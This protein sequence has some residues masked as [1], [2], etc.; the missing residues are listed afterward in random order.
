[1]PTVHP[2][3]S[4]CDA[5]QYR[6][7]SQPTAQPNRAINRKTATQPPQFTVS[8]RVHRPDQRKAAL[9]RIL[10]SLDTFGSFRCVFSLLILPLSYTQIFPRI[11][12]L[13]NFFYTHNQSA[14]PQ[15]SSAASQAISSRR[16]S[17]VRRRSALIRRRSSVH[18]P[19]AISD[20]SVQQP[21]SSSEP[22]RGDCSAIAA[23]SI[24]S[25]YYRS[26]PVYHLNSISLFFF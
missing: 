6:D 1:M 18:S 19:P 12:F 22:L 13:P 7:T 17:H 11:F 10:L 4:A 15:Q 20:L 8:R 21:L 23:S 24:S 3:F 26:A 2:Y 5:F 16:S 14:S 25:D 9:I